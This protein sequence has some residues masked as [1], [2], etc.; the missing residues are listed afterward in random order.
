MT[1]ESK[2]PDLDALARE[3]I[4]LGEAATPG[5]WSAEVERRR[6][7]DGG[8]GWDQWTVHEVREDDPPIALMQH[9]DEEANA[10]LIAAYRTSAPALAQ[11]L[12]EAME[13]MRA[14]HRALV[15]AARGAPLSASRLAAEVLE[16]ALRSG[17]G[18]GE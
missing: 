14:A 18:Q 6:G 11:A 4:A 16:S 7:R 3:T 1:D 8:E 17:A 9:Q 2:T 13:A 10:A 12:L 15:D 5:P